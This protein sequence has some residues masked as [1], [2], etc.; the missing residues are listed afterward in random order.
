MD[1]LAF[2]VPSLGEIYE[3]MRWKKYV[4][5]QSYKRLEKVY[6]NLDDP[7]IKVKLENILYLLEDA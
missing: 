1:S 3:E 4:I 7:L 2:E 6:K 5:E